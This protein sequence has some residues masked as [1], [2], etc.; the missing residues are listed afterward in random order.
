MRR[1][2]CLS[3]TI[4]ILSM[5]LVGPM[6]VEAA[7]INRPGQEYADKAKQLQMQGKNE[8]ALVHYDKAIKAAPKCSDF[9]SYKASTLASLRRTEEAIACY[10]K[11]MEFGPTN[12]GTLRSFG[13]FLAG[14][15]RVDEIEVYYQRAVKA[16]INRYY[17]YLSR[18]SVYQAAGD[19]KKALLYCDKAIALKPAKIDTY[20][21]KGSVLIQ[22][23]KFTEAVQCYDKA[24]KIST[25]YKYLY[26]SA[27]MGKGEAFLK[28]K[29]FKEAIASFEK[30]AVYIPKGEESRY[31]RYFVLHSQ[32]LN[33]STR[34]KD[35]VTILDKYIKVRDKDTQI[36]LLKAEYLVNAGMFQ[37]ALTWM[38]K[39]ITAPLTEAYYQK[40]RAYAGLKKTEEAVKWLSKAVQADVKYKKSAETDSLFKA[41]RGTAAFTD[42]L[43]NKKQEQPQVQT[44]EVQKPLVEF[45]E[46]RYRVES[47]G[48][49]TLKDG[50]VVY[51][52]N[53][54]KVLF[55]DEGADATHRTIH[56][57]VKRDELPESLKNFE[58]YDIGGIRKETVGSSTDFKQLVSENLAVVSEDS[59]TS[60]REDTGCANRY[61]LQNPPW[62]ELV[63]LFDKDKKLVGYTLVL[64]D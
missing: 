3:C 10:K 34:Y 44:Q 49:I 5:A 14:L 18:I 20:L 7:S 23:G 2:S 57:F 55:K 53:Q 4:L 6:L 38:E 35:A 33:H 9:Y 13:T 54:V 40:A 50:T 26:A 63:R 64:H 39:M 45:T 21:E 19:M 30:G 25:K 27:H 48:D 60:Y 32:A 1:F 24:L 31:L 47:P 61:L 56:I 43:S 29:K 22:L 41:M 15:G 62:G 37:Q 17:E 16:G 28:A 52:L 46:G 8:E 51:C 42:A 36:L 58:Y 12:D 59:Y 11:A